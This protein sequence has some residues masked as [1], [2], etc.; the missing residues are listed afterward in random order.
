[1]IREAFG[2]KHLY[3][4]FAKNTAKPDEIQR[5]E[6][7]VSPGPILDDAHIDKH[8]DTVL[9]LKRSAW[10]RQVQRLLAE[11]AE[12]IA[13]HFLDGRFD[14]PFDWKSLFAERMYRVYREEI[15][16]RQLPGESHEERVFRLITEQDKGREK[17]GQNSIR[18]LVRITAFHIDSNS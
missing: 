15:N 11:E 16:G 3:A 14:N 6:A 13:S 18:H 5:F 4:I 17:K 8:G 12:K 7:G 2:V 9:M 1:M 10:N